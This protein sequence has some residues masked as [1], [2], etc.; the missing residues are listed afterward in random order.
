LTPTLV[1]HHADGEANVTVDQSQN[2]GTWTLLGNF[3]LDANSKVVL[4]NL[5][6]PCGIADAIRVGDDSNN[7]EYASVT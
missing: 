7:P 3:N 5:A 2:G 6:H 1:A 4:I